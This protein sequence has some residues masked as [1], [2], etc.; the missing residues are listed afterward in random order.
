MGWPEEAECGG[1][2][3]AAPG[4]AG[5]CR[6][7][8]YRV[9]V[10]T[11]DGPYFGSVRLDSARHSLRALRELVEEERAYL[12]LWDV[13]RENSDATEEYLAIHKRA[14]RFVTLLGPASTPGGGR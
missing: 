12:A 5:R 10:Q 3:V 13:T 14:V 11:D 9:R 6:R 4:D 8:W 1:T 2:A 7:R